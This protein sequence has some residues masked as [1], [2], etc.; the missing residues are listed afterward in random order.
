MAIRLEHYTHADAGTIRQTLIDIHAALPETDLRDEFTARFPWFVD[1]WSSAP[2]FTCVIA[3]DGDE[4]AG[5]VYGAPLSSGREW[6]RGHTDPPTANTSTYGVSEL[7]VG[8]RWRK[9]GLSARLHTALLDGRPETLAVLLVD[10]EHPK[11]QGVYESWGYK[12]VGE[13]RPFADAPLL[14]VMLRIP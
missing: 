1:H 12:K 7:A 2:D 4:P 13:H 3:Y 8:A 9:T 5:F 10:V 6:W 11:V 14:A